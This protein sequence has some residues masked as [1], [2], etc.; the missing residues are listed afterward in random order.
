MPT[1]ALTSYSPS[2][3]AHHRV[4][5]AGGAA[6]QAFDTFKGA[7]R[8]IATPSFSVA[9][10]S[11][12]AALRRTI[13]RYFWLGDH[14]RPTGHLLDVHHPDPDGASSLT[15][16]TTTVSFGTRLASPIKTVE[17]VQG[18]VPYGAV[19]RFG[20]PQSNDVLVGVPPAT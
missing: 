6:A 13:G 19:R 9:I 17:P 18:L 1:F 10:R 16:L 8:P 15:P 7:A 2:P 11:L 20:P 5:H 4:R 3:Y 12:I 14:H